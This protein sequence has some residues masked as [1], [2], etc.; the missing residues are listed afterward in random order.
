[1][2]HGLRVL[3]VEDDAA[4]RTVTESLLVELGCRVTC[5]IDGPA[6][7][8]RLGHDEVF[9]LVISDVVMPGGMSGIELAK[10]ASVARPGLP[11]VLTTG[12]VGDR[13]DAF[14]AEIAWPVLRKPF[15]AEQ[16][17]AVLHETLGRTPEV[18]D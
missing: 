15:R 5:E 2:T 11:F 16:L 18:A 17:R 1:M 10:A 13:S 4:V 12:Y 6:A 7:L 3:L 14:T 8:R 9:D